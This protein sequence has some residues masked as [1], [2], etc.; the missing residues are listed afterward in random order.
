MYPTHRN[1]MGRQRKM[2]QTKQEKYSK[3]EL[4]GINEMEVT[5][6]PDLEFKIMVIRKL[7]VLSENYKELQGNYKEL[8]M[9]YISMKKDIEIINKSQEEIKNTISELKNIVEGIKSRLDE[10]K[11]QISDV[12]DKVENNS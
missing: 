1:Q 8:P 9:N 2:F 7:N 12:E 10:G 4:K 11:D 3:K 5:K 6:I